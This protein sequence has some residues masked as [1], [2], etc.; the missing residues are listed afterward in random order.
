[1]SYWRLFYHIVWAT[2]NREPLLK[3][4][5]EQDLYGY[6]WGKATALGCLPHAINGMQDHIHLLIS[7]PPKYSI[8]RIVGHIKGSS[9][10]YINSEHRPISKFE[11]QSGFGAIS[12]SESGFST[13]VQYVL[14]QK[15]H[16]TNGTLKNILEKIL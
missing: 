9:S 15:Q 10:R 2:K 6:L 7:V 11:W 1:M 16:H 3:A 4:E 13:V 14:K 12:I 5:W 8:S